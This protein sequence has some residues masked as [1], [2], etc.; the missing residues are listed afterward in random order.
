[1]NTNGNLNNYLCPENGDI[2][3]NGVAGTQMWVV[4]KNNSAE[5]DIR[6][7]ITPY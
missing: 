2:Y 4:P 3:Y 6:T 1:V 7:D 5:F